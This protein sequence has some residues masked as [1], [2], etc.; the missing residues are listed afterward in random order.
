MKPSKPAF[1]GKLCLGITASVL[2]SAC[3]AGSDGLSIVDGGIRG[4]G[5]SVGP[6][7]GFGSVIVNGV[8]FRT[9][10]E[11]NSDDGISRE[12][13][14]E[15]G[16]ILQIEGEWRDDGEGEA[17][18]VGYDD[19]F[20]GEV[21]GFTGIDPETGRATFEVIGQTITVDRQTVIKVGGAG[22][23]NG[24]SV[25]VSAWR[26]ADGS[27]RASFV[28][29]VPDDLD[30][31]FEGEIDSVTITNAQR[32]IVVNGITVELPGQNDPNGFEGITEAQLRP[33]F[34]VEVEGAFDG[35][36][37]VRARE[38]GEGDNRRYRGRAGA[39]TDFAGPISGPVVNRRFTINGLTVLF[40]SDT[41]F[42]DG[43]NGGARLA[44]GLLI[45]VEGEFQSDTTVRA[46]TIELREGES[47]V[48]G[49][50]A[51][52]SVDQAAQTLTVGGV[53][54]QVTP[55]TVITQES[56]DGSLG[57]NDLLLGFEVSVAGIERNNGNG[58]FIEAIKI[59]R[60]DELA[61]GEFE[62]EGRLT[63]MDLVS[64]TVLGVRIQTGTAEFDTS[65]S[66]LQALLDSGRNPLIE[67]EY[68]KESEDR[69]VA[70]EIDLE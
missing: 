43:L 70:E 35:S 8:K 54:V 46:E 57:F 61:D 25:R 45:Q 21:T 6:V 51:I 30:A 42:D 58:V 5:S 48:E 24:Q 47:G 18:E 34:V 69:F 63:G 32:E 12:G 9:D 66:E 56:D 19:T 11:V 55:A 50:V 31:E 59:E 49:A 52:N 23:R 14:I 27:Y 67:V 64:I 10:G 53:L 36:S 16:M 44:E 2:L 22:L 60:D 28:G 68:R 65:R 15:K 41:E 38:V 17:D 40:D 4:T 1:T 13:Q 26:T 37:V 20:R 7:S 29:M 62:L 3:G 33:G 39:D